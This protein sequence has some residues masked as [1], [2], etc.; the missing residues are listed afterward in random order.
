MSDATP[1]A[2]ASPAEPEDPQQRRLGPEALKA[3]THPLRTR[4]WEYLVDHGSATATQ[5]AQALG[6]STG[7]TSYHLRQLERFGFI[8]DDPARPAGRE[9]WWRSVGFQVT[10]DDLLDDDMRQETMTLLRAH[11]AARTAFVLGWIDRHRDEP[12]EWL[13]ASTSIETTQPFTAAELDALT[14]ELDEVLRRHG[15]AAKARLAEG[16]PTPRRRV[17][18]YVDA[19]P[20]PLEDE[21][22]A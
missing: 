20:V 8:E 21:P 1:D 18:V 2:T 11:L 15:R 4:M 22:R 12:R 9:R 13:D 16:D 14:T 17:R 5:L 19:L 3:L 7:Q 6:E 10:P